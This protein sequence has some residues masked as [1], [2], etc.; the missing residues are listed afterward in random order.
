MNELNKMHLLF[1]LPSLLPDQK[2]SLGD[3]VLLK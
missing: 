3:K 1:Y 2:S